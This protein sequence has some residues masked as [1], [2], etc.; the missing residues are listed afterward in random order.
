MKRSSTLNDLSK[1]A[2]KKT[3]VE[4]TLPGFKDLLVLKPKEEL[5]KAE[6]YFKNNYK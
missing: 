1:T 2:K 6:L 4:V 5:K 3:E